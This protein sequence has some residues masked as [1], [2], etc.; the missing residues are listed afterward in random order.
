MDLL[1]CYLIKTK[2][3][4]IRTKSVKQNLPDKSVLYVA[5]V[6]VVHLVWKLGKSCVVIGWCRPG[7]LLNRLHSAI[8]N[9]KCNVNQ[10]EIKITSISN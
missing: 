6:G 2:H 8:K 3:S 10:D 9:T 4:S 1:Q 7:H 5:H